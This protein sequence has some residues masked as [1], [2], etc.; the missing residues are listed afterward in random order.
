MQQYKVVTLLSTISL[1]AVT[2]SAG[3]A[4]EYEYIRVYMSTADEYICAHTST[5]G[6][7]PPYPRT[8][9][10]N[11]TSPT[12]LSP[13]LSSSEADALVREPFTQYG[14]NSVHFLMESKQANSHLL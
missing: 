12:L 7:Y 6:L 3:E 9:H 1:E 4:G 13:L 5:L 14:K 10:L 11:F 8:F 2:C